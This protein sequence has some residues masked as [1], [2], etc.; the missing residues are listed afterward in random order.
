MAKGSIGNSSPL[1]PQTETNLFIRTDSDNVHSSSSFKIFLGIIYAIK[2]IAVWLIQ[3]M[4]RSRVPKF[5]SF[6]NLA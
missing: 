6:D 3:V 2:L 1:E 4:E 5:K